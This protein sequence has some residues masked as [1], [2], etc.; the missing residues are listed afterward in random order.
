MLDLRNRK[1]LVMG[2]GVHGGGLGVTQF[3]LRQGA[4]VT[5]TD[6]RPAEQL[7]S[8]LRALAGQPVR[9]VLGEHRREDFRQ[10]EL[11]VRNPA[12]PLDSPYLEEARRQGIPIEMEMTLFFARC[13][14]QILG[15]TGT[16]GKSTSTSLLGHMLRHAGVDTVVAGN[17]RISALE[18]LPR[19]GPDTAVVLELSSWQLEGLAERRMAPMLAVVTNLYPDHLNRYPSWEAYVAAKRYIYRFQGPPD[20]LVL[21]ANDAAVREFARDAPA[22]RVAWFG[23]G[24]QREGDALR[25]RDGMVLPLGAGAALLDGERLLWVEAEGEEE[26][27]VREQVRLPG[28]HNLDNVLAA[29]AAACLYGLRPAQLSGSVAG[30]RGLPDRLEV[31]RELDG[32]TYINDTTSTSPAATIAALQSLSGP[33]ILLAGGADK[34]LP[35]R[36]MAWAIAER[37]RDI[38]LLEG[39]ATDKLY[40]ELV[41]AGV[42]GRVLG[43]FD[44]LA[45]ALRRARQAAGRG[46]TVLLSPGCASF[47]MFRH[48]FE[49]GQR[50]REEVALLEGTAAAEEKE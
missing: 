12:V 40:H 21:N 31:V 5:V 36:D 34:D 9:Y 44:E 22:R 19:I 8:P 25:S 47:G 13:P 49:R 29:A 26:L 42:G 45:A 35:Y 18:A 6:L 30:F 33:L 3:L 1:V 15:V 48:E 11:I 2:L 39:S 41:L 46:D 10:A 28:Q 50:F 32:V 16:K 43:R 38:V 20:G 37:V 27:C 17:I 14:G 24:L 7:A 4:Q 23:V